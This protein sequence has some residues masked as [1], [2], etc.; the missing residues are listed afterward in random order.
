LSGKDGCVFPH[1]LIPHSLLLTLTAA[2]LHAIWNLAAKRATGRAVFGVQTVIATLI[3]WWP[4]SLVEA[5][6]PSIYSVSELSISD[7]GI[8]LGSAIVH[9]VYFM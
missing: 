1:S 6:N 3:I 4:L 2:L 7:W 5:L 9:V 8:V